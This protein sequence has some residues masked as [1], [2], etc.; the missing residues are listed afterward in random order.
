MSYEKGV[1]KVIAGPDLEAYTRDGWQLIETRE[2][3]IFDPG[4]VDKQIQDPSRGYYT[5]TVTEYH[6]TKLKTVQYVIMKDDG[7]IRKD[8]EIKLAQSAE[9]TYLAE[10]ALRVAEKSVEESAKALIKTSAELLSAESDVRAAC[11]QRD[12]ANDQCHKLE[13]AVAKVRQAIGDLKFKEIVG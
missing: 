12:D 10:Q 11:A 6:P 1:Y 3:E 8:Y 4:R 7:S 13:N 5:G 2:V 9:K